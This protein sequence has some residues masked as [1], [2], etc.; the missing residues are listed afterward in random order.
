MS[1]TNLALLSLSV[2]LPVLAQAAPPILPTVVEVG[3]TGLPTQI[4][5]PSLK[6]SQLLTGP[7]TLALI[8]GKDTLALP[9]LV[10]AE[11]NVFAL[12]QPVTGLSL[13]LRY[14]R[15]RYRFLDLTIGNTGDKPRAV[16]VALTLKLRPQ[17]DRVFFPA[18][19]RAHEALTPGENP[20]EYGY[21]HGGIRTALPVGQLYSAREDW[22]SR[23]SRSWGCWSSRGA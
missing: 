4:K 15:D 22:A 10:A 6:T 3:K 21:A 7:M 8:E 13:T 2:L 5:A 14:G 20:R 12:R 19:A 17:A 23:S 1:R 9:A 16:S 11:P 18:T